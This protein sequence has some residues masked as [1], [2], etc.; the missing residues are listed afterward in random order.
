MRLRLSQRKE[1]DRSGGGV[2]SE[3]TSVE[4]TRDRGTGRGRLPGW[5]TSVPHRHGKT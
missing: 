4:N 2:Y 5:D 3:Y 1:G